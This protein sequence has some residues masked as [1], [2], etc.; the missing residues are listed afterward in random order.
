M[1]NVIA[2][3]DVSR[4]RVTNVFTGKPEIATVIWDPDN[5]EYTHHYDDGTVATFIYTYILTP[6]Y[7]HSVTAPVPSERDKNVW[8]AIKAS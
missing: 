4:E 2:G 6:V 3:S 8:R 7:K 5:P 1:A